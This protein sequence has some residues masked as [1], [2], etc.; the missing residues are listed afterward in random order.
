MHSGLKF[1]TL[2]MTWI[3]P[4][5]A[6]ISACVTRA[7]VSAASVNVTQQL[8]PTAGRVAAPAKLFSVGCVPAAVVRSAALQRARITWC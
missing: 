3:T 8:V 6:P 7:G 2:S 1:S 5:D 4:F